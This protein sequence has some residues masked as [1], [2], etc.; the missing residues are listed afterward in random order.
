MKP[1]DWQTLSMQNADWGSLMRS[2]VTADFHHNSYFTTC[3][4]NK[5]KEARSSFFPLT[6]T[7]MKAP[8]MEM[9]PIGEIREYSRSIK[10]F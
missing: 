1:R 7:V 8:E 10:M 5:G 4:S 2:I 6:N 9:Q 3:S